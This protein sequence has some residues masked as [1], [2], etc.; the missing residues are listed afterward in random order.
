MIKS[1]K[2]PK[3]VPIS[4]FIGL[5]IVIIFMLFN[6]NIISY[7]PCGDGIHEVFYSHFVHTDM[8]HLLS[9]LYALYAISRVEQMMGFRSFFWLI[10]FILALNTLAEYFARKYIKGMKCGIG[11][12]GILFG[13][14]SWELMTKQDVDIQIIFAIALMVVTPSLKNKK[15]SLAGHMIGAVSGI[16]AS[17]MWKMI[18]QNDI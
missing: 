9:N 2:H 4:T 17:V 10:V 15:V 5:S 8:A 7:I 13:L 6:A 18:N 3:D 14:M 1:N 12:S 11:F 16:V